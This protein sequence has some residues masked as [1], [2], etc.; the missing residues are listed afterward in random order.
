MDDRP[1][2]WD[3]ANRKHVEEDHPER[4]ITMGEVEAV[5]N[6]P[7]R[8]E[9]F[10]PKRRTNQIVRGQTPAGRRLYVVWVEHRG[11]RYPIHAH[12]IGRRGR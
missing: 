5:M 2:I 3:R 4:H 8:E 1:V 10:H 12:Q 9:A 11:G 7:S 6:D